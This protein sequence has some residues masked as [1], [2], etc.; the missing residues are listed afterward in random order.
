MAVIDLAT[1]ELY[2]KPE[3]MG[4]EEVLLAIKQLEDIAAKTSKLAR[5]LRAEFLGRMVRDGAKL[6]LTPVAHVRV[7]SESKLI[8]KTTLGS[9][10]DSCPEALR[11]KCFS[12]EYKPL[13]RGLDELAKLGSQWHERIDELYRQEPSLRIE[14]LDS[15]RS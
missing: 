4:D 2:G 7:Y 12:I 1:G 5:S 15:D 11:N 8:D 10:Y 13:K 6:R 9:L 14:W 3:G